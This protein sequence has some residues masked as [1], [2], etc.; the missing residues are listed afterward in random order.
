MRSE[1]LG[2][3]QRGSNTSWRAWSRFSAG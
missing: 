2:Q 3:D 1:L